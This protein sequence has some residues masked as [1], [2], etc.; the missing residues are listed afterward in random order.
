MVRKLRRSRQFSS[1]ESKPIRGARTRLQQGG[2]LRARGAPTRET[3]QRAEALVA[4]KGFS[5]PALQK[6]EVDNKCRVFGGNCGSRKDLRPPPIWARQ[7]R[8]RFPQ[9]GRRINW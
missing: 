2:P 1:R 3:D 6:F 7:R 4:K 9:L 5:N 8:R